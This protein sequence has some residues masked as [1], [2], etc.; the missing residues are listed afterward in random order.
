MTGRFILCLPI[1][2]TLAIPVSLDG[3][4]KIMRGKANVKL[5][6]IKTGEKAVVIATVNKKQR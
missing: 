6:D 5:N 1:V 4:T 2:A 3:K